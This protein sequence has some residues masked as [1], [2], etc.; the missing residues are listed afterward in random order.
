[1]VSIERDWWEKYIAADELSREKLT[2]ELLDYSLHHVMPDDETKRQVIVR[3]VDSYFQDLADMIEE[4]RRNKDG[5][6]DSEKQVQAAPE[7][8]SVG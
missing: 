6:G 8:K 7:P 3:L 5:I 1:M 4:L 2:K